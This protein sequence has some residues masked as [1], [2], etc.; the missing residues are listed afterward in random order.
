MSI[1]V[2]CGSCLE[3]YR[4]A[5]TLAGRRIKCRECGDPLMVPGRQEEITADGTADSRQTATRARPAQADAGRRSTPAKGPAEARLD[6]GIPWQPRKKSASQGG[7]KTA[8]WMLPVGLLVGALLALMVTGTVLVTTSGNNTPSGDAPPPTVAGPP[9]GGAP[10]GSASSGSAAPPTVPGPPANQTDSIGFP[11]NPP[12]TVDAPGFGAGVTPPRDPVAGS[13]TDRSPLQADRAPVGNARPATNR[14]AA[15]LAKGPP[16]MWQIQPETPLTAGARAS[17]GQV[18]QP[19]ALPQFPTREMVFPLTSSRFVAL[20]GRDYKRQLWD[21]RDVFTGDK[22]GTVST[23]FVV[24]N[25]WA[26]SPDGASLAVLQWSP[27]LLIVWDVKSGRR[28]GEISVEVGVSEFAAFLS[29][30][31]LA[32]IDGS[33]GLKVFSVP[34]LREV[35]TLSPPKSGEPDPWKFGFSPGGRYVAQTTRDSFEY[36]HIEIHDLT[37][38][39]LVGRTKVGAAPQDPDRMLVNGF[40]IQSLVFSP[41]GTELAALFAKGDQLGLVVIDMATGQATDNFQF[42]NAVGG[43]GPHRKV[44][45]MLDWFPDK[46]RWLYQ[47][48]GLIDRKARKMIWTLPDA[49]FLIPNTMPHGRRVIDDETIVRA[50][51]DGNDVTIERYA[52]PLAEINR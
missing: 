43:Q 29:P 15:E 19:L 33:R 5:D 4:V 3:R 21:V 45:P 31:R 34:E 39:E 7:H 37:T 41:D 14:S 28:L 50:V 22:V 35:Q 10:P 25:T 13:R 52:L 20:G 1:E 36:G 27:R 8:G 12:G 16:L 9:A 47:G 38:G 11:Q 40:F 26:L 42:A 49:D 51:I 24:A 18:P 48:L 44:R 30:D 46:Q 6:E 2:Q 23:N 32:A 17:A